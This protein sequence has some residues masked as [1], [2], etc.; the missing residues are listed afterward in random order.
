[1]LV[2]RQET[3]LGIVYKPDAAVS[4]NIYVVDTFDPT[5]HDPIYYTA[6]MLTHADAAIA[7]P[8]YDHLTGQIAL[9]IFKRHGFRGQ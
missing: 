6:A 7:Q 5:L 2:Q 3:E 8:F 1:M 4:T 9:G